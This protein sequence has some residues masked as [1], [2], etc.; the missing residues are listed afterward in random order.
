MRCPD[1][2]KFV[3][4][5]EADPEVNTLGI[6][7]DGQVNAEVRIVNTCADC[8]TELKE[9]TFEM[10]HDHQHDV[11]N[12]KGEG[13]ELSIEEDGSERTS[14]SGYFLKGK[15]VPKGG[16]YAKTFYGA[17]VDYSV[18]CSC[19]KLALSGS[20][21]DDAQASSMDELT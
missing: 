16:R 9:I 8:G 7:E 15:F 1:C 10:E 21:E 2:N 17:K 6:D 14:R 12:H 11:V 3:S 20:V 19:G 4:F 5:D 18:Q 13:H